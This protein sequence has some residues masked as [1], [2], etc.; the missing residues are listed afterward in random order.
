MRKI[1]V[2]LTAVLSLVVF[3]AAK[4]AGAQEFTVGLTPGL[5]FNDSTEVIKPPKPVERC[6][7]IGVN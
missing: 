7:L 6:H 5:S 2:L 1:N 3:A 4:P